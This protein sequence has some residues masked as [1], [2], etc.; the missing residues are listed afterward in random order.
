MTEG[1]FR[2]RQS[3]KQK[4]VDPLFYAGYFDDNDNTEYIEDLFSRL[5]EKEDQLRASSS[6]NPEDQSAQAARSLFVETAQPNQMPVEQWFELQDE[7]TN[8]IEED[9]WTPS[10]DI[11]EE[12][13]SRRSIYNRSSRSKHPGAKHSNI[14]TATQVVNLGS[15]IDLWPTFKLNSVESSESGPIVHTLFPNRTEFVP[16]DTWKSRIRSASYHKVKEVNVSTILPIIGNQIDLIIM[17]PPFDHGWSRNKLHSFLKELHSH[18]SRTF[19]V[20][21]ADPVHVTSVVEAFSKLDYVFCDSIAVELIDELQ[22]EFVVK[23]PVGFKRNSRMA[24]MYRTNDINRSDLKQQRVKDTGFGI[25]QLHA[26]SYDRPSMPMTVHNIVETMLPP[27]KDANKKEIPRVFVEIWP[28]FFDRR[29]GWILI[30]EEESENL[31]IKD[32]ESE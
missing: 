19:L 16:R 17:D 30:D 6:D 18:L 12:G 2:K 4:N 11:S 20:I 15:G 13:G 24:I 27:R 32:D 1:A 22:H 23:D 14:T 21:W 28:S 9:I 25:I 10:S 3:R 5:E 31:S 26:K 7:L 29:P 8:D